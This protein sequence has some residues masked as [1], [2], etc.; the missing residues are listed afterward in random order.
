M[1]LCKPE[2]VS[3]V[4]DDRVR[5]WYI[6][7]TLDDRRAQ[8]DVEP[9]MVEV[10]HDLLEFPFRHLAVPDPDLA[11]GHERLESLSDPA[12]IFDLVVD[13][14][15]LAAAFDLAQAGF[16]D[17]YVVPFRHEGLDGKSL[18]RRRRDQGHIAYPTEGHV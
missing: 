10:E 15:D 8:Q 6:D 16:A 18:R 1:Q 13:E 3:A 14:I 4:D 7:A 9:A 17:E 2:T 5:G 11:L 12:D